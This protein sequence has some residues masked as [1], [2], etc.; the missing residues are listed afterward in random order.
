MAKNLVIDS[1]SH[2]LLNGHYLKRNFAQN[3]RPPGFYNP[4]RNC[5]DMPRLKQ[6]LITCSTFT[7]Y[8]PPFP[9]RLSA[10]RACL[11]IIDT[12]DRLPKSHPGLFQQVQTVAEIRSSF[13]K[14]R[15]AGLLAIEGGHVIG[16][17]IQRLQM[18]RSR[19]VRLLTLTHFIANRLCDASVGPGVHGGLSDFGRKVIRECERV[20]LVV[21]LAHCSDK[22]FQQALTS[23]SKPPLVTHTALRGTRRNQRYLTQEQAKE[24]AMA[25]GAIGVIWHPLYLKP[26]CLFGGL[27]LIVDTY[28]RLA[29]LIGC[30]HLILGSDMDGYT[31]QP[32]G[33]PDTAALPDLVVAMRNKGFTHKELKGIL[34]EN[35]LRVLSSWETQ[36]VIAATNPRQLMRT[37][38]ET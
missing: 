28:A 13:Q 19:G 25:Q 1:H 15:L 38:G 18:L 34:G 31:L 3:H 37:Q 4:L 21:D 8:V 10:W 5:I 6:G 9:F 12:F 30:E 17:K 7:I 2:F 11:R 35:F 22:A 32:R 16:P 24:I 14:Q 20:G 23:L 29:D 26:G 27:D 36:V 33:L